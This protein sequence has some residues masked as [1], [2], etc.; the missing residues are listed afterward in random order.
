M[1]GPSF[2]YTSRSSVTRA[3]RYSSSC[4]AWISFRRCFTSTALITGSSSLGFRGGGAMPMKISSS[5][6]ISFVRFREM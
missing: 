1:S 3:S 4:C 6:R 2:S 5:A